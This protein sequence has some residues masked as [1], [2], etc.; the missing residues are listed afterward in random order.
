VT[1]DADELT[2]SRTFKHVNVLRGHR[3]WPRWRFV[4]E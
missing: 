1:D 4:P 2:N 3:I